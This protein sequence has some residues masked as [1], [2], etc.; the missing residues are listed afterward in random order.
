MSFTQNSLP[1]LLKQPQNGKVQIANAD[2]Q[3]QKV[4]YTAGASGS[5]VTSLIAVSTDTTA[6][7]VQ[8]SITNGGVSYPLGTVSVPIG[9]GNSSSV[10]SVNLL[11]PGLLVGLAF[12]SDGNP[13]ILLISGDTLTVSA[14]STVTTAKTITVTAP[15]VGD[16]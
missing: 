15:A 6:R 3:A 8:V 13:E 2:A 16:F 1:T 14:L 12:D 11:D 5:K 4:V 10:P 9:A 7:D